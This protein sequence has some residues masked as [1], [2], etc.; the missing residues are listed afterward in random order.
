VCWSNA[1]DTELSFAQGA[2]P[3]WSNSVACSLTSV[4]SYDAAFQPCKCPRSGAPRCQM[5]LVSLRSSADNS[6][7]KIAFIFCMPPTFHAPRA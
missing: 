5:L 3:H 6:G 1:A 2:V 7:S 4:C